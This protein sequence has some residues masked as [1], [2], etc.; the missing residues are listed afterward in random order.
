MNMIKRWTGTIAAGVILAAISA[1]APGPT[2]RPYRTSPAATG[3]NTMEFVRKQL[4]GTWTLVSLVV[5]NAS[6][7]RATPEA[8]GTLTWDAFGN[9]KIEYRL[10]DGGLKAV[11]AI[12]VRPP[13]PVIVTEGRAVINTQDHAIQYVPP[14]APSRPF[15]PALAAARDNPFALE[16][17]RY[18]VFGEDGTLTLSTRHDNGQNAAVSQWKKGS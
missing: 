2:G 12:G 14:D 18:Y 11:E 8:T 3:P 5:H 4:E 10:S 13:T 9:L 7:A 17:L 1:C 16:R 6:G 15:D